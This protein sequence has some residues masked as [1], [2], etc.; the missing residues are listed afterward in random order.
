MNEN[1]LPINLSSEKQDWI[2]MTFQDNVV[3][4]IF[5]FSWMNE[6][7]MKGV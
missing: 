1:L 3:S 7:G 4:T 5:T 6:Q 2:R